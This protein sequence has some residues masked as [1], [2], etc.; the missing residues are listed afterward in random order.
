MNSVI[1]WCLIL[2]TT[3]LANS[4]FADPSQNDWRQNYQKWQ[5]TYQSLSFDE[6]Q[7]LLKQLKDYPLYPYAAVQFFQT[8]IK[9]VS[10]QSVS[11]FVKK[12]DH[13]PLTSSL[14]QAYLTELTNRQ[15][16]NAIISFPKDNSTVADCRYQYAKLQKNNDKSALDNVESLWLTGNELPSDCDPLLDIWSKNGKRTSNLILLRIELALENNNVKL[17]RHLTSLLDDNYQTTKNYLLAVFNDPR[18]LEQFSQNIN[19][20]TFTKKIVLASYPRLVKADKNFAAALLPQLIKKQNLT[21]EEQNRLQSSLANSYFS[22]SV[23]KE[24]SKWRDNYLAK[25]HDTPLV[26][27]RIRLAIDANN[28]QDIAY[29]ITQLSPEDQLKEEWQYWHARV[30]L[31]NKKTNEAKKILKSLANK[32]GFYGMVSAQTL[33]QPYKINNLSKKL[34]TGELSSLKNKYDQQ[35]F[36]IRIKELRFLGLLAESKQEWRY[37]LNNQ[38]QKSEYLDLAKYAYHKG[39]GDLSIQATISGKLWDNWTERLPIMYK[40]LYNDALKDKAIPLSYALAITRQES[41]F[42]TTVKSPVGASGLMQLMPATAKDTAKKVNNI[43]YYS[44]KQLLEPITNV[45]LGT[46][47]LNNV[48]LQND[49][50]RILSS[51]AYNAGPNRVKK[52]LN[53]SNGKLDAVAFIESIPFNETRNYVKSVLVYDHIYQQILGEKKPHILTKNEFNRQY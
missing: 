17:A 52:W 31:N 30:L 4:V 13:F 14:T 35:P 43:T 41:A 26:E 1:R 50:N 44:P 40:N 23:T 45:H 11:E 48:Y 9:K 34:P 27:K 24:Q 10:P 36:V 12:Y 42:D 18:K 8:N 20:S 29:W 47:Y 3:L 46:Y 19:T 22:D 33:N 16:W 6:Q 38:T 37:R 21:D 25:S 7:A 39:W 51:A 5:N 49:N 32:R 53:N 28:Y 15:D 2:S